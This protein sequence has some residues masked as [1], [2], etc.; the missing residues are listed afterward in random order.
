MKSL[1]LLNILV[2]KGYDLTSATTSVSNVIGSENPRD[3]LLETPALQL[4][5]DIFERHSH[6]LEQYENETRGISKLINNLKNFEQESPLYMTVAYFPSLNPLPKLDSS[7][8]ILSKFGFLQM[9]V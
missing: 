8:S 4:Q 3:S 9:C 5:K 1:Q 2:Q 6:L 7:K